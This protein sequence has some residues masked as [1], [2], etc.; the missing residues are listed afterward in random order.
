MLVLGGAGRL[1]GALI[2][3]AVFMVAQDVLAGMNPVYWQFWIGLLL[4]VI[5]LF[6]R[7]GILGGLEAIVKAWR[8]HKGGAA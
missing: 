4:M 6:A 5:V 3:A 7:G 8:A 1:Y 2:G